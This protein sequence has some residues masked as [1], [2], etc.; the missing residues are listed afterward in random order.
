[1]EMVVIFF[2][3]KNCME[4]RAIG[5]RGAGGNPPSKGFGCSRNKTFWLKRP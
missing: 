4:I 3:N 1:M 2:L 5:T